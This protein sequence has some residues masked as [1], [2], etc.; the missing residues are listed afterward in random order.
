MHV[1]IKVLHN[2]DTTKEFLELHMSSFVQSGRVHSYVKCVQ[3]HLQPNSCV[4]I[5]QRGVSSAT[6]W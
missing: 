5:L 2:T 3:Y 6:K 4:K 1:T